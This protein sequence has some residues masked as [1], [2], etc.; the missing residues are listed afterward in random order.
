M[1][2]SFMPCARVRPAIR[3]IAL[4]TAW[5]M[6][7]P[8]SVPAAVLPYMPEPGTRLVVSAAFNA[9]LLRGVKFYPRNI[10]AADFILDEGDRTHSSLEINRAMDSLFKYFLAGVTIPAT[11]LWVNLSPYEHDRITST[12]L[13]TTEMGKDLLGQDYVLKQLASSLTYPETALGKEFWR[14]IYERA[15]KLYGTTKIPV[16]TFN[17][18]WIVP[19]KISLYEDATRIFIRKATLKVMMEED[20]LAR[21]AA[22][23]GRSSAAD[24]AIASKARDTAI[25]RSQDDAASLSSQVMR[26]VVLPVIEDEVNRGQNFATLRQVYYA[27]VLGT[28]FKEKLRK[29]IL[30]DCYVDK[31]KTHGALTADLSVKEKIYN[32]YLESVKL[33]AYNYQKSEPVAGSMR[34]LRRQ[35]YSGGFDDAPM[36]DTLHEGERQALPF[37]DHPAQRIA[38]ELNGQAHQ[39]TINFT[40]IDQHGRPV[41]AVVPG[42][43]SARDFFTTAPQAALAAAADEDITTEEDL[44][45]ARDVE[46]E[47]SYDWGPSDVSRATGPR[48]N[49]RNDR[50]RILSILARQNWY[51]RF[52]DAAERAAFN[53]R[54]FGSLADTASDE[55]KDE[56]VEALRAKGVEIGRDDIVSVML[57]GSW[58]Y[59]DSRKPSDLD[60][61]V[62]VRGDLARMIVSGQ[63]ISRPDRI[64]FGSQRRVKTCDMIIIGEDQLTASPAEKSLEAVNFENFIGGHGILIDG[65]NFFTHPPTAR[66]L[67]AAFKT[68]LAV[69]WLYAN[70]DVQSYP[71]DLLRKASRRIH[72]LGRIAELAFVSEYLGPGGEA[73]G[74]PGEGLAAMRAAIGAAESAL[75]DLFLGYDRG[76]IH[77]TKVVGVLRSTVVPHLQEVNIQS[78]SNFVETRLM[79]I[80]KDRRRDELR[81][82]KAG[83]RAVFTPVSHAVRDIE[84]LGNGQPLLAD[85]LVADGR[86]RAAQVFIDE[87]ATVASAQEYYAVVERIIAAYPMGSGLPQNLIKALNAAKSDT[88][89]VPLA[90]HDDERIVKERALVNAA[91]VHL[92]GEDVFSGAGNWKKLGAV[93]RAHQEHLPDRQ[94]NEAGWW[95]A[96][97]KKHGI[98]KQAGFT[99]KEIRLLMDYGV[100]GRNVVPKI[101]AEGKLGEMQRRLSEVTRATPGVSAGM[102]RLGRLAAVVSVPLLLGFAADDTRGPISRMAS[103]PAWTM[104]IDVGAAEYFNARGQ[105][106]VVASVPMTVEGPNG[107]MVV[108]ADVIHGGRRP[109]GWT[110]MPAYGTVADTVPVFINLTEQAGQ[111]DSRALDLSDEKNANLIEVA[112]RRKMWRNL[113]QA[114]ITLLGVK[115]AMAHEGGHVAQI[116]DHAWFK[117]EIFAQL[118]VRQGQIFATS[119]GGYFSFET[120][121]SH[122][123]FALMATTVGELGACLTEAQVD[124]VDV[125]TWASSLASYDERVIDNAY[126]A[127]IKLKEMAYAHTA[128]VL[129][130]WFFQGLGFEQYL[131]SKLGFP[132]SHTIHFRPI[133]S[134]ATAAVPEPAK[135]SKIK[136]PFEVDAARILS[137]SIKGFCVG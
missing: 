77:P 75:N 20:Y 83:A 114:E 43:S 3:A 105:S 93:W 85:S 95:E 62:V 5:A 22:S 48:L 53:Q 17:K 19:G 128:R 117:D 118:P 37:G 131:Q 57:H 130:R 79:A 86:R 73:A 126:Y 23:R 29:T 110:D 45:I 98:L 28:W 76:D 122:K 81:Q 80:E 60:V 39:A 68:L 88:F 15:Q 74:Y 127:G 112:Y 119:A 16:N 97:T 70:G 113:S 8:G 108:A 71:A 103:P 63:T 59:A 123:D 115:T 120:V 64:F 69:A 46:R 44:A 27:L 7:L 87:L 61:A 121:N 36:A 133:F 31:S 25:A 2:C 58:C 90:A 125:L 32:A 78:E 30:G 124:P 52:Y 56:A 12:V 9:A 134:A 91:A 6:L 67:I 11:D 72:E 132:K 24:E 1:W 102:S 47:F 41:T 116:G 18:I 106:E 38:P 99:G 109:L 104:G 26:E 50:E 111:R 135:Q 137:K 82:S 100:V 4:L 89:M 21:N 65:Y 51:Y 101:Q 96:I 54:V 35:Y 107:T 66:N 33:G 129:T 34:R 40:F 136:S 94:T 42:S 13:A 49:W 92:L 10:F 84:S 14:K 55:L